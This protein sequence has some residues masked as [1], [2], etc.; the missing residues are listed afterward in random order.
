[1]VISYTT[2]R[3]AENLNIA[4]AII[5][6]LTMN[7]VPKYSL[8]DADRSEDHK[9]N[10]NHSCTITMYSNVIRAHLAARGPLPIDILPAVDVHGREV[11]HE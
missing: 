4:R 7:D 11:Q 6:D 5:A 8:A 10:C 2:K 3:N 1:M 9:N